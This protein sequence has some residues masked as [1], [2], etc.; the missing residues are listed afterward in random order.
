M[1]QAVQDFN[2]RVTNFELH[3]MRFWIRP[4]PWL[5]SP[6]KFT[7]ELSGGGR[8]WLTS[9]EGNADVTFTV[10]KQALRRDIT[11]IANKGTLFSKTFAHTPQET[12]KLIALAI[13]KTIITA[14]GEH[15]KSMLELIKQPEM[16]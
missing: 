7:Y 5:I 8:C 12:R 10:E 11:F 2:V 16:T 4:A 9:T 15:A 3:D 14:I 1:E 6:S 13:K